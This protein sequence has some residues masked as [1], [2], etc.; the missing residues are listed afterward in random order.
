M[1][2][3]ILVFALGF[4]QDWDSANRAVLRLAPSSFKDLPKDIVQELERRQC[5]IPQLTGSRQQQNVIHGEF[6]KKGQTDWA[7]LC[8][9]NM[10]SSLL[11]FAGGSPANPTKLVEQPDRE[12]LQVTGPG[13][14]GY[15]WLISAVDED[16]ILKHYRANNGPKP[17][18]IDHQGIDDAFVEKA[19]VIHYYYNR[20]WL[21][22]AGAD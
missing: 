12:K 21:R 10:I 14:I 3:L 8:S 18:P 1:N 4:Y 17:P 5:T 11:V 7:V 20:K 19:S 13:Q 9:H 2:L 6:I 15:S 22:L 16:Y